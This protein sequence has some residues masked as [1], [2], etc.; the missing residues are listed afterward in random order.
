M[1]RK[2][3]TSSEVPLSDALPLDSCN[4]GISFSLAL[5]MKTMSHSKPFD[6]VKTYK[7]Y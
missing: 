7:R 6:C 5:T 3:D 2:S 1:R 4:R